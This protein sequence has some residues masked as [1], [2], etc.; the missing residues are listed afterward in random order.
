MPESKIKKQINNVVGDY[1]LALQPIC[2]QQ[3]RHVGDELLYRSNQY[4]KIA[5]ID[6]P[7]VATARVTHIAFYEVG[8]EALT[9]SRQLFFNVPREWILNPDFLPPVTDHIV[10]EI[11]EDIE[12]D[13]EVI[14]A[15]KHIKSLGYRIALDDFVLSDTNF[16]L[17]EF[18]DIVKIDV[19]NEKLCP[20]TIQEYLARG[21]ILLAE[22]VEDFVTYQRCR[23]LGFTLFQGFFYAHPEIRP[24]Q[25]KRKGNKSA[26]LRILAALNEDEPAIDQIEALLAQD[27]QLCIRLLRMCNSPAYRRECQISSLRQAMLLVGLMRLRKLLVVLMLA[28]N[29]PCQ[30]L[31]LPKALT[32]ARMCELLALEMKMETSD[33]AFLVGILSMMDSLL[34]EPLDKLCIQL[35]LSE[36]VQAALLTKKGKLGEILRLTIAFEEAQ[37]NTSSHALLERLNRC[38][39]NSVS[40]ATQM[41]G[42]AT[43][44]IDQIS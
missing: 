26:Q 32:R 33:S 39:L 20:E 22:K 8:I 19:L 38:Y 37:L 2:D 13:E 30:M 4:A 42:E 12:A 44:P 34:D 27:P 15:L 17:L 24:S 3:L 43:Q 36:E 28:D 40:W 41:L 16:Q 1:C 5:H 7:L 25:F 10:L 14:E 11:L 31:L 29:D 9:G 35:P 21:L 23:D 6:N 18:A